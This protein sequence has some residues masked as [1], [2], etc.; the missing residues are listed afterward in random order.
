[1][2][3]NLFATLFSLVSQ[4]LI[5]WLK[6]ETLKTYLAVTEKIRF[7]I[8]G[9]FLLFFLLVFTIGG[10]IGLHFAFFLLVPWS[11]ATKAFVI[12]GLSVLYCLLAPA[13]MILLSRPKMIRRLSGLEALAKRWAERKKF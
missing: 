11:D 2:K 4:P 8:I 5:N 9:I 3:N 7:L 13:A 12:L 1:M 6:V 10:F